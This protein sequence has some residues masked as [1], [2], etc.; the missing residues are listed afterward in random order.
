MNLVFR[1]KGKDMDDLE[2]L[3]ML[4]INKTMWEL[5]RMFMSSIDARTYTLI[6]KRKRYLLT[7]RKNKCVEVTKL[8]LV[9]QGDVYE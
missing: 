4:V 3:K 9:I 6:Y 5:E 8:P 1:G 7:F 2:W